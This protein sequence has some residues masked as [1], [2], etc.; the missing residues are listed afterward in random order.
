YPSYTTLFSTQSAW[1]PAVTGR[2]EITT[3]DASL[4]AGA[5]E[6]G[7]QN[8]IVN[9]VNYLGQLGHTSA[10]G[11]TGMYISQGCSFGN[12]SP[13]TVFGSG[14]NTPGGGGDATSYT[15]AGMTSPIL[16]GI[17]VSGPFGGNNMSWGSYSHGYFSSF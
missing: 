8:F 7:A 12:L 15:A 3:S 16:S 17:A 11:R 13:I 14:L 2:V 1:G 9:S 6:L 5:R 10:G 4:H